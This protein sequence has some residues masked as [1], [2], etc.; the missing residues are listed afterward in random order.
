MSKIKP[1]TLKGFRD[2]LP[3]T[4][5]AREHLM[6]TVRD[7]YRSF[8]FAPI[9][10][11][12]LEYTEILLGKGGEESD[13]QMFRFTD[14]GNRDVS[15]RF[16]LT[17]PFARFAAQ[18]LNELGTPF[19]RY[20]LGTVWRAEK[21]QKGRYREFVQCDF[22]TIGTKSNAA[23]I[24]TLMVIHELMDRIGCGEFQIRVNNRKVLN[25][26]LQKLELTEQS[27]S[28]L[29]ALDKLPK[30]GRDA[31][32]AEMEGQS[33]SSGQ[34]EQ[35][36]DFAELTGTP[37]ELLTQ[38][39]QMVSG[40]ETGETGIAQL[41]E[42]FEVATSTGLP[43]SRINLDLSIARGLDYY[44]GTIYE[45]FLDE[46]PGIGSVCSGGR[47]DNLAELFTSQPLPGVGASLGLDRLLAAMEELGKLKPS[48]TPSQILVTIFDPAWTADSF[49]IAQQLR[50][51][52][53][54]VEVY[55]DHKKMG[56]QFQYA[57]KKGIPI[58]L[59]AGED[60][61]SAGTWQ[62]K[63]LSSGDQTPIL[64][65]ELVDHLLVLLGKTA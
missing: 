61:R 47:Y 63:E 62:V 22:D 64:E 51:S 36:L 11:P 40:N 4:M 41:R 24:E 44:T 52:G 23:D 35:V 43:A 29:R 18:H 30:I 32:L 16:D 49:R 14:Q 55:T 3:E 60:E 34:A 19:K 37:A 10:T 48:S 45:T 1:Q 20:H 59:I 27:V 9:D 15:M 39:E 58:V 65:A 42:L 13:K 57:D 21:P 46:L 28:V 8:G 56:K 33:I 54:S 12:A 2:F 50:H 17:V 38:V 7:V 6:Q 26:L 53:L 31:V 25:G 5:L